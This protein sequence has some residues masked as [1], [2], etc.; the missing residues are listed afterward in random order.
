MCDVIH[1]LITGWMAYLCCYVLLCAKKY[2][3]VDCESLK[4][5]ITRIT[6]LVVFQARDAASLRFCKAQGPPPQR[7]A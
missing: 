2:Y 7:G 1:L 3:L 5:I 6:P 4:Y